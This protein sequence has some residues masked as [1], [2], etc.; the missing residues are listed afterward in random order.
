M[1]R[2]HQHIAGLLAQYRAPLAAGDEISRVRHAALGALDPRRAGA[3]EPALQ[4]LV[5]PRDVEIDAAVGRGRLHH[6]RLACLPLKL[7]RY[8]ATRRICTSSVPS[9]MR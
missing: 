3:A 1:R 2:W 6:H 9:V 4:V 8:C 7:N 5:K